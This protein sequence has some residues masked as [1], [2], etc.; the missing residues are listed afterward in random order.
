M[1]FP[2]GRR[3]SNVYIVS[4]FMERD[5]NVDRMLVL[6]GVRGCVTVYTRIA[7]SI[8]EAG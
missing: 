5:L 3:H 6:S 4:K 1:V 7:A 8:D 2:H